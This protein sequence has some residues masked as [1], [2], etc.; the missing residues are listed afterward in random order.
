MPS[1]CAD[2]EH[3]RTV[4]DPR[5]FTPFCIKHWRQVLLSSTCPE[6]KHAEPFPYT[7][8]SPSERKAYWE[9]ETEKNQRLLKPRPVVTRNLAILET[10]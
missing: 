9:M 8:L 10:I 5:S 6:F 1:W 3:L 7:E 4:N 2:C